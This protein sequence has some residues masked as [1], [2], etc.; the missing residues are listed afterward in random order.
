MAQNNKGNGGR[1][2]SELNGAEVRT[3][4]I[5]DDQ[6]ID[7]VLA[8]DGLDKIA[9]EEAF[10][11]EVV[12]VLLAETT[13]ENAAPHIILNVNGVNQPVFRGVSTRMRRC[14]V[15]VLARCKET[16]YNQVQDKYELDRQEL[17]ARTAHAYPFQMFDKNP[18]GQAWLKAVMAEAA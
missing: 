6:S 2:L 1:N 15:E 12:E 11:H 4:L 5:V 8:A 13:D 18:R 7:P 16:K 10:M 3:P 9:A 17:K 14:F